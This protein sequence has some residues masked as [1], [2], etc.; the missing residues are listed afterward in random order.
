MFDS[1]ILRFRV[2]KVQA[3]LNAQINN[4]SFVN[5]LCQL[6]QSLRL[7]NF[8][9]KNAY[10]RKRKDSAFLMVCALMLEIINDEEQQVEDRAACCDILKE[11]LGRIKRDEAYSA[12][13]MWLVQE[14]ERTINFW[15]VKV[16]EAFKSSTQSCDKNYEKFNLVYP[17][18]FMQL[19][20]CNL[21]MVG[22]CEWASS[23][24]YVLGYIFGLADM[25]DYQVNNGDCSGGSKSLMF[26]REVFV[27]VFGKGGE[28]FLHRAISFQDEQDFIAGRNMG[29]NDFER[30]IETQGKW[31]VIGLAS[32]HFENK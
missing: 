13:N 15:E 11:R 24:N 5:H 14:C 23:D 2:A 21:N 28:F 12:Q 30:W 22:L 8:L 1:I 19:S 9:S 10:Y 31:S 25:A 32:Y 6:P 26:I 17:L 20:L 3:E 7:I 16:N 27:S 29:C 4:Q 18:I